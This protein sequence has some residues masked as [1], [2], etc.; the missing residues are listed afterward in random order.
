M[1]YGARPHISFDAQPTF[2]SRSISSG[3]TGQPCPD[4]AAAAGSLLKAF[5]RTLRCTRHTP[6]KA[7]AQTAHGHERSGVGYLRKPENIRSA[8]QHRCGNA[9][10]RLLAK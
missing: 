9:L 6:V 7:S 8:W 2:Y 10:I 5:H 1:A 3:L 4:V